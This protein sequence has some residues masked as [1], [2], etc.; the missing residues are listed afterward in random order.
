MWQKL[1]QQHHLVQDDLLLPDDSRNY[2]AVLRELSSSVSFPYVIFFL[3]SSFFLTPRIVYMLIH[4]KKKKKKIFF[5][6]AVPFE[7]VICLNKNRAIGQASRCR[8]LLPLNTSFS[9]LAK[10]CHH[11]SSLNRRFTQVQ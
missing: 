7:K 11:W 9:K 6:I 10:S 1:R 3:S 5:V 4:K 8:R 2:I